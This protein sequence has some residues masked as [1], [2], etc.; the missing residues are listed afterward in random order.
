M[1]PT[2][3]LKRLTVGP[4]GKLDAG[5]LLARLETRI[6]KGEHPDQTRVL[7]QKETLWRRLAPEDR[8][9]WA[10]LAQM[11]EDTTTARSILDSIN[12]EQPA[13]IDAWQR[14]LELLS[15]LDPGDAF[16][17]LLARARPHIGEAGH[18]RWLKSL[19]IDDRS[20]ETDLQAAAGPFDRH[21]HR[22]AAL[23]RFM[24][25]FT[26]RED[27]FA[28][29]W[30]NRKENKQGYVPERRP[31]GPSD[32]EEHLN[33]RK[34]YGIYL[35]QADGRIRTAVLDADLKKDLRG[36]PLDAKTRG[37]IRREAVHLISRIKELSRA[38][39]A[40]P[41]V[42]FSG[43]KGYH[44]W[45]FFETPVGCAPIRTALGDLVRRVE[46]DLT[47]FS[48]EVFPKQDQPGGK[49][50][51][52]LVKLPLGLHRVTGKRSFFL[53]CADRAVDAQLDFL[54]TVKFSNPQLLADRLISTESARVVIH[55]RW[56]AWADSYPDLYRLQSTCAPLSQTMSLCLDGS[57]LALREEKILYQTIGFLPDGQRML[58]YLLARLP[59]YNPHQV[60]YRLSRLRGTPLGCRR[61]HT[62]LGFA[63]AFCRF[64]RK[65]AYLHPLL[66]IDGWQE[67]P[68]PPSEKAVDLTSALDRLQ[69]AIVQVER[70]MK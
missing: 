16:A 5:L 63:G 1:N 14:H 62:L 57:R 69:T 17:A 28:R 55:P 50:F 56:K 22:M 34:T 58:H 49:G 11:A 26:G 43:A 65:A 47:A 13:F 6:L 54:A 53:D 27:C 8:L 4:A 39:G 19:V 3:D 46:P 25:L 44:F 21:H 59:D 36:R 66:H 61:I 35:M 18:S 67:P 51:G 64:T 38:A 45:F 2:P 32:L 37:R 15:I 23:Q 70:F 9:R 40:V 42:E 12:R 10:E 48:L 20:E 24:D 41:L 33:G 30:A 68:I 31:M 60:D 7:L 29:Q 52:N